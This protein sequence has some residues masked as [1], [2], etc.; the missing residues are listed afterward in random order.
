MRLLLARAPGIAAASVL[1]LACSSNEPS[2]AGDGSHGGGTGGSAMAGTGGTVASGGSGASGGAGATGGSGGTAGTTSGGSGGSGASGGAGANGTGT[3]G[4][5]ATGGSGGVAGASGQGGTGAGTG[6]AAT[7]GANAGGISGS[8]TAGTATGGAMSSGGA[9]GATGGTVLLADNFDASSTLDA[10][11]FAYPDYDMTQQPKIDTTRVHSPPNA[12]KVTSSSSGSFV[13]N[14]MGAGF[15]APSN[16]FYARVWVNFE[17]T[18]STISGHAAY[19]VGGVTKDN[20]GTELR[21]G[22]SSPGSGD[23]MDLNLQNPSDGGGGEVTRFSNGFTTGG[24]PG[25]F[26]G[27]GFQY[28][29][30]RWYCVEALFDGG[31]SEF[32]VWVDGTEITEMHVHDF[33][34]NSTP[35]TMWGPTFNFIKIGGQ[36]FSGTIGQVWYDDVII[37]TEQVGC[38]Q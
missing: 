13:M 38:T 19:L 6:G 27:A 37:G 8:G 14:Q 29:A 20:S 5:N 9:A 3:G 10:K 22:M 25:D 24:N 28:D 1:A 34:A 12:L 23:M 32:R 16:R 35:R 30:N 2:P 7:G 15:P 21:L 17:N 18:T 31:G 36:N 26:T 4:T 33:S 11:W